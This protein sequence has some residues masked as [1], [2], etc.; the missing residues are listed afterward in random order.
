MYMLTQGD[1]TC[2]MPV[3]DGK[4]VVVYI[5][6]TGES[7]RCHRC[8]KS[9]ICIGSESVDML[10]YQDKGR[11][12]ELMSLSLWKTSED[13]TQLNVAWGSAVTHMELPGCRLKKVLSQCIMLEN[14]DM[15]SSRWL[16]VCKE[17]QKQ[18]ALI[19]WWWTWCMRWI[20]MFGWPG[21][22]TTWAIQ[23]S[24]WQEG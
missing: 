10:C 8:M 18:K 21:K 5:G 7:L 23:R 20:S 2:A 11:R 4:C 3:A 22:G 16:P 15:E 12:V 6:S 9:K 24:H 1:H 14:D 13:V 19:N 17:V